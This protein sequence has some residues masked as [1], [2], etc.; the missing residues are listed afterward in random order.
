MAKRLDCPTA[1]AA[2]SGAWIKVKNKQRQEFV[3]GGWLPDKD[4]A[5]HIGALLL[6]YYDERRDVPLR[7]P[8]RDGLQGRSSQRLERGWSRS[9]ATTRR[10]RASAAPTR[11]ALRR[12]GARRRV[13]FTEWTHDGMMRHPSFKGLV[14]RTRSEATAG[15]RAGPSAAEEA[16]ADSAE[17]TA[18]LR[19]AV[20]VGE[21]R[22]R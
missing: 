8:R 11:R 10:S 2:R 5:E 7:R 22:S 15:P 3:V 9:R 12:A 1:R 21:T 6:G 4:R 20:Q 17:P 19:P 18:S 13:E 14:D 16:V